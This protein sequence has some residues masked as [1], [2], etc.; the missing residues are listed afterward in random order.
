LGVHAP[1]TAALVGISELDDLLPAQL[2]RAARVAAMCAQES[3]EHAWQ[4]VEMSL[5]RSRALLGQTRKNLK[6][7]THTHYSLEYLNTDADIPAIIKGLR[8]NPQGSFCLYG[9]SGTGKSQLAR[10]IADELGKPILIK[11]PSD[12]FVIR[13]SPMR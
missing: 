6:A 11:R 12:H 7:R 5:Q 1:D 4:H 13:K 8:T 3:P 10:H 2:E 9:P